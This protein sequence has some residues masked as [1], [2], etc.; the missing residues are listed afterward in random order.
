MPSRHA[1]S[2]QIGQKTMLDVLYP[3]ADALGAGKTK[4]EIV[5]VAV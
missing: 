1:A 3:V 5:A 2:P 4:A